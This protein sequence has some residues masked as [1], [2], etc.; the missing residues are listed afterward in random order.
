TSKFIGS[1]PLLAELTQ[2]FGLPQPLQR[3]RNAMIIGVL[4]PARKKYYQ[5][6]EQYIYSDIGQQT[7]GKTK[8]KV[9]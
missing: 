6:Y 9:R 8:T 4:P 1:I 5:L 3:L 7:R 2:Q